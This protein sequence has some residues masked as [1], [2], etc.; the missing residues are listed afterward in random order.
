MTPKRRSTRISTG[1]NA[2]AKDET[3][4][5]TGPG[6]P[7]DTGAAN[8]NLDQAA[9]AERSVNHVFGRPAAAGKPSRG[10]DHKEAPRQADPPEGDRSTIERELKRKR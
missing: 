2:R 5:Q 1:P 10:R 8:P 6:I 7:D 4:A 3:I 9:Q